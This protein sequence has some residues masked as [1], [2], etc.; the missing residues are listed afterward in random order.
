MRVNEFI[1]E[2]EILLMG[3]QSDAVRYNSE[4]AALVAFAGASSLD[5][6]PDSAL[7]NPT[8][9]KA[10]ID[11]VR[12][13]YNDKI[14]QKWY[15]IA[16]VYKQKILDHA[17]S[18][19]SKYDWVAGENAGE[20]ADLVFVDHPYSGIS[21]KDKGGITLANL[22][23][24]ALGLEPL[25]GVD[26]FQ[27]Y[28]PNEYMS[29]KTQAVQATLLQANS[30]P[31]QELIPDTSGTGYSIKY[32]SESNNYTIKAKGTKGLTS[33][34]MTEKDIMS[35]LSKNAKWQRVFGDWFQLNFQ[36]NKNMM[37]PLVIKISKHFEEL[38]SQSLEDSVNLKR[39]LQF[40]KKPYYYATPKTIYFVPSEA[41]AGDL[42]LKGI[43]YANP[44]GTS[45]LWK[46]L[47]GND[48][49]DDGT[50]LDLYI[51]FANGL[52][53]TNSTARVQSLKNPQFIA[54]DK[55]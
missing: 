34:D 20:V 5:D 35:G 11:K 30:T 22:T 21:L 3:G 7:A 14:F 19:P 8:K 46:A 54:W 37:A 15:K 33:I 47:I 53:A 25:K 1:T 4:L 10:E 9:V 32:N 12:S 6:I 27:H 48:Q 13:S 28:A 31:D 44:D 49:S 17:G 39:I 2:R 52:F 42:K 16:L 36:A 26:V 18:L 23:P 51:R 40:E 50:V 38:M 29:W 41:D 24:K 45:Q 43:S 55:L